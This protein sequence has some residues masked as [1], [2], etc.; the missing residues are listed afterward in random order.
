[1]L[2]FRATDSD[3]IHFIMSTTQTILN[4]L[5]DTTATIL[6]FNRLIKPVKH[7]RGVLSVQFPKCIYCDICYG[8]KKLFMCK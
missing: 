6:C 8:R 5:T 4:Q 1:M 2:Y 7:V 3:G